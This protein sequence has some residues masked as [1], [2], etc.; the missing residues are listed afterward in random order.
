MRG[1]EC[2]ALLPERLNIPYRS[3][4]LPIQRISRNGTFIFHYNYRPRW[5]NATGDHTQR[6]A[7]VDAGWFVERR[8]GE[9]CCF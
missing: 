5:D 6:R 1:G 2:L 4:L 8:N 9:V 7:R 3:I